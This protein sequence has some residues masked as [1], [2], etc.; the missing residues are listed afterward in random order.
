MAK[1]H[2]SFTGVPDLDGFTVAFGSTCQA[3]ASGLV[4]GGKTIKHLY[5]ENAVGTCA[6]AMQLDGAMLACRTGEAVVGARLS[7]DETEALAEA[8]LAW[9]HKTRR[10]SGETLCPSC[11]STNVSRGPHLGGMFRCARC[12]RQFG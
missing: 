6:D 2:T 3:W 12:H 7:V 1:A 11:H 10:E 9:V 5:I 4:A 8:M